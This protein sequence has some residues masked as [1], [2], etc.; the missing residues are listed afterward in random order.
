MGFANER[1]RATLLK[2]SG[3][4][5]LLTKALDL[6]ATE[7]VKNNALSKEAEQ[8]Y[9]TFESQ[10][11]LLKGAF[12][13]AFIIIG[14][15]VLPV[16]KDMVET[17]T[18]HPTAIANI[19]RTLFL[20]I[21]P[22]GILVGIWKTYNAVSTAWIGL[23]LAKK[24]TVYRDS[25][26][27]TTSA[28]GLATKSINLQAIELG[29]LSLAIAATG[30]QLVN[31]YFA[32]TDW[33][34]SLGLIDKALENNAK[35]TTIAGDK[36]TSLQEAMIELKMH[37]GD[38][39]VVMNGRLI[40]VSKA[41]DELNVIFGDVLNISDEYAA[42]ITLAWGETGKLALRTAELKALE[43][44]QLKI[45]EKLAEAGIETTASIKAQITELGKLVPL[46]ES[47]NIASKN[48]G[49]SIADLREKIM[50]AT[51]EI[52]GMRKEFTGLDENLTEANMLM[53]YNAQL[54]G[55]LYDESYKLNNGTRESTISIGELVKG[56]NLLG[57]ELV[58]VNDDTKAFLTTIASFASEDYIT[59][60]IGALKILDG[61][62]NQ[63]SVSI[64]GQVKTIEELQAAHE[65]N[66]AT[67]EASAQ[68]HE[69]WTASLNN[70][71]VIGAVVVSGLTGLFGGI[72]NLVDV[73]VEA[74]AAQRELQEEQRREVEYLQVIADSHMYKYQPALLASSGNMEE[75]R[76]S[77]RRTIEE[78]MAANPAIDEQ[79]VAINNQNTAVSKLANSLGYVTQEYVSTSSAVSTATDE[80]TSFSVAW[81]TLQGKTIG[82]FDQIEKDAKTVT[83]ALEKMSFFGIDFETSDADEQIGN[84]IARMKEFMGAL[85]PNSAAFAEAQTIVSGLVSEF[86]AMGGVIP[87]VATEIQGIITGTTGGTSGYYIDVVKTWSEAADEIAA[88]FGENGDFFLAIRDAK[89]LVEDMLI[90]GVDIDTTDADEKIGAL[91]I[92]LRS[93]LRTITPD[94]YRYNKA[95]EYMGELLGMYVALG[96]P[97]TIDLVIG[98]EAASRLD[99]YL[100][101]L[102]RVSSIQ[103]PGSYHT[104]GMITAHS[105]TEL[106]NYGGKKQVPFLGLE[107]EQV[108]G[109]KVS[110]M[111]S[112]Q[113]F[114]AFNQTGDPSAF[115]GGGG[116]VTVQVK[117]PGPL[118]SVEYFRNDT[119]RL[120]KEQSRYKI[121][122]KY[123]GV[124]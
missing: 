109:P 107:G 70:S 39:L 58:D 43:E 59:G 61:W 87:D 10:L 17:L 112:S 111:Y 71:S 32:Y 76:L 73:T 44:A 108:I 27:K 60:A 21:V 83:D 24:F 16:L 28:Q 1:T 122:S 102:D 103:Y 121:T 64:F 81:D 75:W 9:K 84:A 33:R 118:T 57:L 106:G 115:G 20:L 124:N 123:Y 100:A 80:I 19:T 68:A 93:F 67:L 97:V 31:L 26:I 92:Q 41:L 56:M 7:W 46:V 95:V 34:K 116:N 12:N 25:L 85:D 36:V 62:V 11:K 30:Q 51:V 37:K 65:S 96:A 50:P 29:V 114:S 22:L 3:S 2:L 66:V 38:E 5:E 120:L 119:D 98:T 113:Q 94:D 15:E 69:D 79:T 55:A 88:K 91:I 13:E 110:D 77:Q 49:N 117:E 99:Y 101:A 54:T 47:D 63:V 18:E 53:N 89:T 86:E 105:G 90:L 74:T 4:S 8:R 40:T 45:K 48:L 42:T 23:G 14:S 78:I 35:I 6:G 72:S 52:A 104:G 82:G